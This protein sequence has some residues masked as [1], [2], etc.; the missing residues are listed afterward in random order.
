MSNLTIPFYEDKKPQN[1]EIVS[2]IITGINNEG[3]FYEGKLIEY[4]TGLFLRF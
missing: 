2:V 1:N 3:G 4:S